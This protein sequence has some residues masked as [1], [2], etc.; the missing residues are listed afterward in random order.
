MQIVQ[1]SLATVETK[2][3]TAAPLTADQRTAFIDAVQ[4]ALGYPFEIEISYHTA[5]PRS[6]GGKY[7][8]FISLVEAP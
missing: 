6:A 5:L 3:V 4:K 8:D 2:L 1:K 7:E